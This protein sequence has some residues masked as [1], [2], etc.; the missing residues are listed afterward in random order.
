MK[1]IVWTVNIFG[2]PIIHLTAAR[3]FL[4]RSLEGYTMDSWL[5]R[6]RSFERG[7]K[8]YRDRLA[9]QRWKRLLPDGAPWLGGM[10]KKRIVSHSANYLQTFAAETRRAEAAHWCMLL[11]TPVF[12]FW[13]PLWACLVMTVYGLASNLP[14]ILAQRANRIQ[15]Q[16]ILAGRKGKVHSA[17]P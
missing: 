11:C 12:Y 6:E 3:I 13:N 7:G 1:L 10:A 5:T 15:I 14:C 2:W 8:F 4:L 16:R 9:I 17:S